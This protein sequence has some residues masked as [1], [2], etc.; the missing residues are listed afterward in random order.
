MDPETG[1]DIL[2][3]EDNPDDVELTLRTLKKAGLGDRVRVARTGLEALDYLFGTGANK[4]S[5]PETLPRLILLDLRLP[6]A[7]GLRVLQWIRTESRTRELPVAILTA[8]DNDPDVVEIYKLGVIKYLKK[9]L[10]VKELRA[11]AARIGLQ[12]SLA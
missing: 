5:A 11:L 3:V 10:E 12:S 2:L 7:T 6:G 9:P 8:F 1:A 4:G